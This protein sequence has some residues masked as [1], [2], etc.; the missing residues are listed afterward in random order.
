VFSCAAGRA[1]RLSFLRSHLALLLAVGRAGASRALHDDA[2][3]YRWSQKR[4]ASGCRE[5]HEGKL[6]YGARAIVITENA[7]S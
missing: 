6:L 5:A 7:A 2:T 4:Q 3:L 1:W